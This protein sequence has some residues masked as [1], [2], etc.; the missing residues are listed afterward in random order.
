MSQ[1]LSKFVVV[2]HYEHQF[3]SNNAYYTMLIHFNIIEM[4]CKWYTCMIT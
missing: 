4:V 3:A 1:F 2:L